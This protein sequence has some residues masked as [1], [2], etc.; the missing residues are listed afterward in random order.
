MLNS[1]LPPDIPVTERLQ[2]VISEWKGAQNGHPLSQLYQDCLDLVGQEKQLLPIRITAVR[3]LDSESLDRVLRRNQ[4]SLYYDI[5]VIGRFESALVPVLRESGPAAG[6]LFVYEEELTIKDQVA[7]FAHAVGHLILNQQQLLK[8]QEVMLDPESGSIHTDHLA[9]LRYLD[10][11][12]NRNLLD[13]Q[14]LNAFPK[15]AKL[16]ELPEESQITLGRATQELQPFLRKQ[17]WTGFFVRSPYRYTS[18]RVIPNSKQHGKRFTVDALLRAAASLPIAVVHVQRQEENEDEAVARVAS[19]AQQLCVPFA[20]V[21]TLQKQIIELHW[22]NGTASAPQYRESL[23]DRAELQTRWLTTLQLN[24][25]KD[26][27]TLTY[28]YD[29]TQQPRY[30]QEIAINQ[31]VIAV[32]QASK[33]LRPRRILLTLATGTGKTQVAFQILWKLKKSYRVRNVLFLADRGYLLEQAKTNTFGPFGE[34]IV[35]GMGEIDIAH[36]ILFGSYQW[37]TGGAEGF[38]RYREYPSDY[39][40]VIIIDE[41][42]RGSAEDDSKWRKALEHFTGA[43]QIGLTATPL[44]TKDVQT[45]K[46]FGPSVYTYSLSQGINDGYLAPYSVRRVLIEQVSQ[47]T[48]PTLAPANQPIEALDQEIVTRTGAMMKQYTQTIAEHL[49]HYLQQQDEPRLQKTIVFCVDNTHADEMRIA[50]ESYCANWAKPGDI[51][52]IV[53]DDG[54]EGKRA[55][56]RFC[57]IRERQPVIVTTARLLT[58]GVD[59]PTCKNIVLARN[60][61][62]LVEFKQIIGR[63]TRL[64]LPDKSWFTIIDYAGAIKH[65]SD[66][67][68]DG[69]PAS[70]QREYLIPPTPSESTLTSEP[71]PA[72]SNDTT[73]YNGSGDGPA[74]HQPRIINDGQEGI[75]QVSQDG[76]NAVPLVEDICTLGPDPSISDE[77]LAQMEAEAASKRANGH[78]EPP[79][80]VTQ[81]QQQIAPQPAQPAPKTARP[82]SQDIANPAP[83]QEE[84]D[85]PFSIKATRKPAGGPTDEEGQKSYEVRDERRFELDSQLKLR[86]NR[87]DGF[88]AQQALR[89]LVKTPA[90]LQAYW[91]NKGER[92]LLIEQLKEKEV[93]ALDALAQEMN[94]PDV[95]HY[96]LLLHVLFKQPAISRRE[97]VERLR[98]THHAFFQRY[99]QNPLAKELLETILAKYILGDAPDVSDTGLLSVPPLNARTRMEWARAFSQGPNLSAT[100]KELQQWLY[101]V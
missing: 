23:P 19:A 71:A 4:M 60:V 82:A 90:D 17:G 38:E 88:F 92:E 16:V 47:A 79:S 21:L 35:R 62:S 52:R 48:Q 65:F 26:A 100:L 95:D 28:P 11:V 97:R 25:T 64:S 96:D 1:P 18:G 84:K 49:A 101:S 36:D 87:G 53:D 34:G 81:F 98:T 83:E 30:Y 40:D 59:V 61:G 13:R 8:E 3:E 27:D 33:G 46:Y 45:N 39:F 91:T 76:E 29:L 70:V 67:K 94:M 24:N 63:G 57:T 78:T 85:I 41:C 99:E 20:Y 9:E 89:D 72:Q 58:T 73:I 15:L 68:F 22:L 7:L 69:D 66:P 32:L 54:D 37:L 42:H 12:K 31:A 77:Q 6:F 93:V 10:S 74:S 14:V 5:D 44:E 86:E 43:I 75:E 80:E 2:N 50:L 56:G 55:L 51:V